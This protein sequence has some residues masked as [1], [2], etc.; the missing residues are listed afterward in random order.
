MLRNQLENKQK[1]LET[2]QKEFENPKLIRTLS[3]KK[4]KAFVNFL[5][6]E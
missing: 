2:W 1:E 4:A 3:P 6:T 5:N